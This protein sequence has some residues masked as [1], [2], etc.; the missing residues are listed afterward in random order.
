MSRRAFFRQPVTWKLLMVAV[1][2]LP[3]TAC[4][5][6]CTSSRPPIHVNPNMDHQPK[7]IS[8]GSSAF[9]YDGGAMRPPVPGTVARGEPIDATSFST[10]RDSAGQ[11]IDNPL[12]VSDEVLHRGR[13]R[14]DI[15]CRPC[16]G[17][18]GDGQ[19][20]IRERTGIPSANLLDERIRQYPDG[21]IYSVITEGMGLMADYAS[22]I[23]PED[24]W[25]IIHYIRS[26][27]NEQEQ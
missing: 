10:G 20:V 25:R 2:V 12:P 26:L 7:Y 4:L 16:H 22:Q 11:F 23:R 18:T 1:L 5:R 14:Y 9:F 17:E 6:G 15:F 8:Q 21:Q 24:R 19:S 13:E 27:Q 3:S